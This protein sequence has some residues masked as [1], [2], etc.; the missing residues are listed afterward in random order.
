MFLANGGWQ[1]G[2]NFTEAHSSSKLEYDHYTLMPEN[3]EILPRNKEK[4]ANNNPDVNETKR[5]VEIGA[6]M[7]EE[8]L[9]F[10]IVYKMERK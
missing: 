9:K 1:T 6:N 4:S 3:T 5:S 10:F 2:T 8:S 7:K